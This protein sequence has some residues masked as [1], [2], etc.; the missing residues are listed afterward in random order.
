MVN[1]QTSRGRS[2]PLGATALADGVNFSLLCRHGTA[3]TLVLYQFEDGKPIDEIALHPH[4]NRTGNHWHILVGGLPPHFRYGW[5][6]DGPPGHGHRYNPKVILIDPS[7]TA[8]S[9]G[10]E[11]GRPAESDENVPAIP[12]GT[13]GTSRRSLF[14]RRH[15][16]WNGDAPPLT[17][18]EDSIIY[19][20]HVRGFTCHPSS[21]VAKPGTF[22]G[23]IEKIPYLEGAGRHRRRAAAD[24]RIRRV[25][26]PVQQ[27]ADRREAAGFLGLQQHRLRR[28][29]G[30]PTPAPA[31]E[32]GQVTEFRDMVQRLPRG[33]HR[34]HPRRRLQPHRRGRRPRPNLFLSRPGQ[35]AVLHAR[36]RRH[37]S[38]TSPAAATRSIATIRS[39]AS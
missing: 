34:G 3:V 7:T 8:I 2:I 9:D 18:L 19:E 33:G 17:P 31:K 1:L 29:Q 24:P 10:A 38:R 22:R 11:W 30:Q 25:R 26:L 27:S 6:V 37:L 39:S 32:H 21:G 35:R 16:S 15:Y 20:L 13:R 14:F 28:P 4:E 12:P 5:R 23:L 36:P